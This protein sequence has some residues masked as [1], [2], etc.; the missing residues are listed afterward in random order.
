MISSTDDLHIFK[1]A[2]FSST[3]SG[4]AVRIETLIV[5]QRMQAV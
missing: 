4:F 1:L 3:G 5:P 2:G